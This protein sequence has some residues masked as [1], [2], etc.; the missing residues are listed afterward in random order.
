M[1]TPTQFQNL[2]R[3]IITLLILV[4]IILIGM[5]E[6]K[7]IFIEPSVLVLQSKFDGIND[8]IVRT[9]D[10]LKDYEVMFQAPDIQDFG[11][12]KAKLLVITGQKDTESTLQLVN[13]QSKEVKKINY[14]GRFIGEIIVGDH[15]FVLKVENINNAKRTYVSRL[16]VL[17]EGLESYWDANNIQVKEFNPQFLASSVYDVFVN[18]SGTVLF[19]TGVAYK[20]YIADLDNPDSISELNG[21]DR[22]IL[23][24][25]N[26]NQIA[27]DNYSP[28]S[29]TR[30]EVMDINTNSSV[31]L[32]L[33]SRKYEQIII[34]R[35]AKNLNYTEAKLVNGER[36]KGFKA[37]NNPN[38]YFISGFSFE[39]VQLNSTNDYVLFNKASPEDQG[40][41]TKSF[42]VYNL[43][44]K[45]IS[46]N[47]ISGTKAIWAR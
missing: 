17:E 44:T 30:L 33:T 19:F 47:V 15:K 5:L 38:I 8:R 9:K 23:G 36:Y 12:T 2:V 3:N 43:K 13:L 42:S 34:N 21:L 39:E 29:G 28:D 31:F 6:F 10:S 32:P 20:H 24:F 7:S 25:V 46:N 37:Y 26:E 40:N 45:F 11:A 4:C 22:Q 16:A 1:I 41:L 27:F 14:T 35:D 18:S